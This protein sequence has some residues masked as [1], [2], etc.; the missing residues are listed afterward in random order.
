MTK[1]I[2][3]AVID[4]GT[5]IRSERDEDIAELSRSIE[6]NG[7]LSPLVVRKK[8]GRF[9][10]IC[11]HRRYKAIKMMG[12]NPFVP[13]IIRDDVP[14]ADLRKVQL[15]ENIQ[16]KS[17]SAF[18]LVE[19]FEQMKKEHH[20]R[21]TN[22]AI[23]RLL[24]KPEIWVSQQYVAVRKADSL[25]V[26]EKNNY[27]GLSSGKILGRIRKEARAKTQVNRDGFYF[28]YEGKKITVHCDSELKRDYV[29][30][31]LNRI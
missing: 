13:C 11:G 1:E 30:S 23:A 25:F 8:D 9:E 14:D 29:I 4:Y 17:M 18:E 22:R 26:S 24:N 15:E 10:V 28:E 5:N 2:P 7:L 3:L 16:R 19:A 6:K 21:L 31:H 20:G 27:T 12:G